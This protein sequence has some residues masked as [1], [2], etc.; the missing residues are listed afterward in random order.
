MP[1]T[2]VHSILQRTPMEGQ[3]AW[4]MGNFFGFKIID[5]IPRLIMLP[6]N[7]GACWRL[8]QQ[9]QGFVGT[10]NEYADIHVQH[11]V[12]WPLQRNTCTVSALQSRFEPWPVHI[13]PP[14]LSRT[15]P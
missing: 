1:E 10:W 13:L 9:V 4:R 12:K 8:S 3:F 7:D 14:Y 5:N 6:L 11:H 2:I 15:S